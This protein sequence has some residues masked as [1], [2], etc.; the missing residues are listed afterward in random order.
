[1]VLRPAARG[2]LGD[3]RCRIGP[4]QTHRSRPV[5]ADH[6]D[7]RCRRSRR[8]RSGRHR[9]RHRRYR[10]RHRYRSVRRSSNPNF[11]ADCDIT[12]VN[13]GDAI[14]IDYIQNGLSYSLTSEPVD[15]VTVGY[16]RHGQTKS[17]DA[18][19]EVHALSGEAIL[20]HPG[21]SYEIDVT[22]HDAEYLRLPTGCLQDVAAAWLG[23]ETPD[24]RFHSARPVNARMSRYWR[25][26]LGVLRGEL[27]ASDSPLA[28]PII[29]RH[30]QRTLAGAV[31]SIFPNTTMTTE[32]REC[33]RSTTPAAVRRAVEFIDN[34][35]HEPLRLVDIANAARTSPRALQYAF[36]RYHDSTPLGYAAKV[37]LEGAHRDLENADPTSGTTVADIARRWGYVR[38]GHFAAAYRAA[39]GQPPSH[40]LRS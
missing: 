14:F 34:H 25:R 1:M 12:T 27:T 38:A 28:Y 19:E 8:S 17:T 5:R 24:L 23:G 33:I 35:A 29:T 20:W 16:L 4:D 30:L 3:R 2:C 31:L 11:G 15:K 36:H 32:H 37:R 22:E 26:L 7:H 21:A 6:R 10:R 18:S 39:Y 13:V 40:T 9:R